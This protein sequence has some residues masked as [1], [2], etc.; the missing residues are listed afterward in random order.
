MKVLILLGIVL[1]LNVPALA[2]RPAVGI[3]VDNTGSLRTQFKLEVELAKEVVKGTKPETSLSLFRFKSDKGTQTATLHVEVECDV[4]PKAIVKG[5]DGLST[6]GGQTA[7]IDTIQDAAEFLNEHS[8]KCEKYSDRSLVLITDGEDRVSKVTV[9][10][11]VSYLTKSNIR[12]YAVG[13]TTELLDEAGFLGQSPRSKAEKFLKKITKETG[14]K[15][16]F[17]KKSQTAEEIIKELFAA[18][19]KPTK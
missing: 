6:L 18:E 5:I 8:D 1:M 15:V 9:D 16:V 4:D 10:K 14:G 11:L 2:Q 7:L 19:A 12:V 17:P 3:L 13:L